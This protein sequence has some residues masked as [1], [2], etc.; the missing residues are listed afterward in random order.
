MGHTVGYSRGH[1]TKSDTRIAVVPVGYADGLDR[2]LGN[3]TG[4]MII[5]GVS[6]PVVG[7]ICMD[8]CMVDIGNLTAREG[9]EVI[10]FGED[11]PISDIAEALSTIPYE[12]FTNISSRVKRVYVQE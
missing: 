6:V 3:G 10:V 11:N 8:M 12:V 1:K 7:N 9:D 5:N 2:R 4:R